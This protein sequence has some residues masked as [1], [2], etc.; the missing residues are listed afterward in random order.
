MASEIWT[1]FRTKQKY[2]WCLRVPCLGGKQHRWSGY[3]SV[4]TDYPG[5]H[6]YWKDPT[7]QNSYTSQNN[8]LK[9]NLK[10]FALGSRSLSEKIS[11]IISL[12]EWDHY[13]PIHKCDYLTKNICIKFIYNLRFCYSLFRKPYW[14]IS[15]FNLIEN[16]WDSTLW[17]YSPKVFSTN[18]KKSVVVNSW[19]SSSG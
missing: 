19:Y 1:V 14:W 11:M 2:V 16:C 5:L 18:K 13:Q 3:L 7:H 9:K 12:H 15:F 10:T 6:P 8:L 4:P 17:C